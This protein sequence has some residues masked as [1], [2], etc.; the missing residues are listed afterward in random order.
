MS[1][2]AT[3]LSY[4][5]IFLP[6]IDVTVTKFRIMKQLRI[7]SALLMCLFALSFAACSKDDDEGINSGADDSGKNEEQKEGRVNQQNT[8]YSR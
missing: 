5:Y 1:I 8:E 2:N 7:F 3:N 6:K 4:F